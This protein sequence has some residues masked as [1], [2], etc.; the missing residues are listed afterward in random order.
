MSA[1]PWAYLFGILIAAPVYILVGMLFIL[2]VKLFLQWLID[3]G[4]AAKPAPKGKGQPGA[5]LKG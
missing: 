1:S 2:G 3:D 4:S 5:T